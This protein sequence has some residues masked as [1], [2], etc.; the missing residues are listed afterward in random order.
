MENLNLTSLTSEE[1]MALAKIRKAEEKQAK[2]AAK[3]A[4]KKALSR[5]AVIAGEL[6]HKATAISEGENFLKWDV[7]TAKYIL[8]GELPS[9]IA[10]GFLPRPLFLCLVKEHNYKYEAGVFYK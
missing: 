9:A 1:L 5:W 7:Q 6:V 3:S 4:E 2:S 8:T 10:C